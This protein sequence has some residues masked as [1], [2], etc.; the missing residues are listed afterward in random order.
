MTELGADDTVTTYPWISLLGDP[1]QAC[2]I[3]AMG[4]TAALFFSNVGAAFGTAKSGVSI[5]EVTSIKPEL[6]FKSI[7]PVVMAG[8]LGMYGLII[9]IIIKQNSKYQAPHIFRKSFIL[10][11]DLTHFCFQS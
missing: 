5:F 7:I 1:N 6:V 11:T 8:I 4:C 9:G 10:G 3:G 2:G